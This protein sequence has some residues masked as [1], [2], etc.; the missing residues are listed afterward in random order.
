MAAPQ[1]GG[2][3]LI[4]T[5][6]FEEF[7]DYA[8]APCYRSLRRPLNPTQTWAAI[9]EQLMTLLRSVREEARR[10]P[11][12]IDPERIIG[13]HRGLFARDFLTGRNASDG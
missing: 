2:T 6:G 3:D 13:W 8:D 7:Q 1:R 11:V 12:R 5:T 9:H 4:A 10:Q